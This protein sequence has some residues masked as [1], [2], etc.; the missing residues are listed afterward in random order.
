M[1]GPRLDLDVEMAAFFDTWLRNNGENHVDSADLFVRT[2][3]RPAPDLDLHEGYWIRDTWPSKTTSWE[4]RPLAGPRTLAVDPSVGTAAWIDCA[5][6][7]PWGLSSDQR[8]DDARSLTW[9]LDPPRQAVVGQPRV[10]VRIAAD[11]PEASLSVKLCDV[12]PDGT[13]ALIT[14]GTLDLRYRD[15][16]HG[17][18]KLLSPGQEYDVT[19]ELDACAYRIDEGHRLRVSVA[20]ADW[21]NT[22]APPAPVTLTVA[23]GTLVLPLW[24]GEPADLGFAPG[25]PT[26]AEDATGVTW[27]ITDDVLART[28]KA[29]VLSGSTYDVP[30]DGTATESYS[31]T[32]TVDRRTFA[33]RA[34]AEA[35][36]RLTWPGVDI[37]VTSLLLVL[38]TA[39]AFDVRIETTAYDGDEQV[40]HRTWQES[41]PR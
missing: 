25:E 13:S 16:V 41:I 7:L 38:I 37:R 6:H 39:D 34:E 31:G 17:E 23:H 11:T 32:V 27:Q 40:A 3:T 22:I 21:P 28:T 5:G 20:G 15:G 4:T 14:R 26:S 10:T 12:F 24:E 33:Q 35:D 2:S 8:L 29:T 1:P 18:A 36:L 19:V 9:D 30:H